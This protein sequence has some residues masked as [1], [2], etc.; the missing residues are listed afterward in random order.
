MDKNQEIV[1]IITSFF[2]PEELD[3]NELF[4]QYKNFNVSLDKIER[5]FYKEIKVE[6][7]EI[8]ENKINIRGKIEKTKRKLL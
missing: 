5:K 4:K 8:L 3:I 7:K 6:L 1:K 2:N